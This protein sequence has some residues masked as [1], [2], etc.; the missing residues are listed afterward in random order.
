M[1]GRN[2]FTH[3]AKW[4]WQAIK[5]IDQEMQILLLQER[6]GGIKASRASPNNRNACWAMF[7]SK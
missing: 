3:E 1:I 5:Q 6:L 2:A 4:R 7:G